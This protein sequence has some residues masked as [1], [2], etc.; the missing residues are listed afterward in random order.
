MRQAEVNVFEIILSGTFD[1]EILF[2]HLNILTAF[3]KVPK[4]GALA[5]GKDI[6]HI[7]YFSSHF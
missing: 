6:A 5:H 7:L 4:G 2:G 3:W 1:E